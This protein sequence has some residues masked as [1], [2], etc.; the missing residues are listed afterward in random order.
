LRERS[1]RLGIA[2]ALT[3]VDV[4]VFDSYGAAIWQ[5]LA[6]TPLAKAALIG[7]LSIWVGSAMVV[8]LHVE[9]DVVEARRE[10]HAVIAVDS[11]SAVLRRKR[12]V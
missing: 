11:E 3:F 4:V 5:V 8:W 9:N 12:D 2:V 10:R 6:Q 7:L 1:K